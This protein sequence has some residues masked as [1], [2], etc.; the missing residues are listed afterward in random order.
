MTGQ[1]SSQ[2]PERRIRWGILG[3]GGIARKFA[4]VLN[5]LPSAQLVAVGSRTQATADQFG[6]KFGVRHRH[7]SYAALA[8][9]PEVEVVYIS[10]VHPLHKEN[11]LLCL[12]AG[13]AVLCE[14]PFTI[15]ASEATAAIA[16]ARAK[17]LF[18]MEAMWPRFLPLMIRLR[19]LLAG[20]VIGD[21]QMLVA[22]AGFRARFDPAHRLFAPELGGGSLLDVGIYPV[23]FA[24]MILGTPTRI[25][26][27]A[28]LGETR[29][30]EQ[31]GAV[32]G[33]D[34]GQLAL[35]YATFRSS[36]PREWAVM[37]TLGQIRIHN[38]SAGTRLTVSITGKEDEVIDVPFEGIDF[39]YQAMEVQNCLRAGTLESSVMPLDETVAIMA[40]MDQ[41][42]AQWGLRYPTE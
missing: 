8:D 17:R 29:V 34:H 24:S 1:Q 13:K 12:Q 36:V 4:D 40:T 18:L 2:T 31:A 37:G 6:D 32:L 42:R 27:M 22:N 21:I 7:A 26:A 33:Y 14:K 15:N 3:T 39:R 23:S 11:M 30:D 28:Q 25:T 35:I 38:P 5:S 41:M 9:D 19:E 20:G 10:T 16:L